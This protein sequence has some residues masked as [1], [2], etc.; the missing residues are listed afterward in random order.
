MMLEC[1]RYKKEH[2]LEL[3]QHPSQKEM[4]GFVSSKDAESL[5]TQE[6]A[7]TVLQDGA[8]IAAIGLVKH[9]EGRYEAWAF[10]LTGHRRAFLFIHNCV[11]KF[12]A[13]ANLRRI[14][15]TV[16]LDFFNGHKWAM[17]LGFRSECDTLKSYGPTGK[18][19][20]LYTFIKGKS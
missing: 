18:D 15:A 16:D 12:L 14:E 8:P 19:Y 9:W 20:R 1:V 17:M 6:H 5:E 11:R 2:L 10:L 7:F 4:A 13:E 3:L